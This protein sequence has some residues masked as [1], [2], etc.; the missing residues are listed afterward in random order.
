MGRDPTKT[1]ERNTVARARVRRAL[2]E[3]Q[4]AQNALGRALEQLSPITGG[5]L[6]TY[7]KGHKLYDQIHAYWYKVKALAEQPRADKL[8][9]D[10]EPKDGEG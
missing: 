3:I 7:S 8:G 2:D 4:E 1:P 5:A 6:P 9:L 10:R